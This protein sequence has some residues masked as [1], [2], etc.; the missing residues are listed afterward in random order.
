MHQRKRIREKDQV[1][2]NKYRKQ[3]PE[4]D[5]TIATSNKKSITDA[6]QVTDEEYFILHYTQA[7]M[8]ITYRCLGK[9]ASSNTNYIRKRQAKGRRSEEKNFTNANGRLDFNL[10][11]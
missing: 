1:A 10:I 3:S 5:R 6:T 2:Y 11:I 8:Q 9:D 7:K 4:I